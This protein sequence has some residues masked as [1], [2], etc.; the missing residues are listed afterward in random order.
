[1]RVTSATCSPRGRTPT[2]EAAPAGG[3]ASLTYCLDLLYSSRSAGCTVTDVFGSPAPCASS[4]RPVDALTGWAA[5][6]D[7]ERHRGA[8]LP[9]LVNAF[10][11]ATQGQAVD[12]RKREDRGCNALKREASGGDGSPV[13]VAGIDVDLDVAIIDLNRTQIVAESSAGDFFGATRR[14]RGRTCWSRCRRWCGGRG[15][16]AGRDDLGGSRSRRTSCGSLSCC[17]ATLRPR[18]GGTRRVGSVG[19]S[20]CRATL[21]ARNRGG[22]RR[23]VA[24]ITGLRN[25]WNRICRTPTK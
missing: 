5:H 16:R 23:S 2:R 17:R 13:E 14:R 9:Q 7:A 24:S 25:R 12:A 8:L 15:R 21:Y 4:R 10:G 3:H 6:P 19:L 11:P 22:R 1:L 20:R 18:D